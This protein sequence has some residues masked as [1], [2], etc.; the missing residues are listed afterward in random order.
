M[1]AALHQDAGAVERQGLLD[2]AADLLERQQVALG[3]ARLAVEGAEPALVDAD[4]GVVDV[5]VDV[6]GRDRGIVEAVP[7]LVR[8]EAE[9]EE[10]AVEEQGMGVAGRDAAAGEGV[11]ENLLDGAS[12]RFEVHSTLLYR[13]PSPGARLAHKALI[14]KSFAG[15]FSREQPCAARQISFSVPPKLR[16]AGISSV[17]HRSFGETPKLRYGI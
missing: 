6:V 13:I 7:H 12:G 4:V 14:R 11:V 10:V 5:A 17:A 3:V 1:D 15:C 8:G 2:L 9:V 16:W